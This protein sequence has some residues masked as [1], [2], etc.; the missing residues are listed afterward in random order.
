MAQLA[1][2]PTASPARG[3]VLT[4][5]VLR[6]AERLGLSGGRLGA[7]I[8]VSAPTISRMKSGAHVLEEGSKPY[9]LAALLVRLFRSL[10]AITGGDETVVRAWM[11]APNSA[12]GD[13]PREAIRSISGL[14]RVTAY[15]DARRALV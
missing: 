5:A 2:I 6:A 8:G 11:K 9:E 15:L 4:K 14:T 10:D 12:L 1:H 13:A 3:V 7:V